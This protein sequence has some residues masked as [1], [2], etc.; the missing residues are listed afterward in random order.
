MWTKGRYLLYSTT[1]NAY[2]VLFFLISVHRCI[3]L[4]LNILSVQNTAGSI[5]WLITKKTMDPLY[6]CHP[7]VSME[8][9]NTSTALQYQHNNHEKEAPLPL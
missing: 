2:I 7:A 8:A 3:I 9:A 4:T 5:C 6:N 1:M